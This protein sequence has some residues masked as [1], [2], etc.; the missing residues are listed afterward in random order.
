MELSLRG[1]VLSKY[2]SISQFADAIGWER[3]K[4]SRIVNGRQQPSK[5]D[6]E[7]MIVLL[8]IDQ[9]AVAPVFFGQMFTE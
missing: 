6:M 7:S 3:G 1:L 5:A 8:G 9:N 2:R 4:A